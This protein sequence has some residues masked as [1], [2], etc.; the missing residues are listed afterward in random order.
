MDPFSTYMLP[1]QGLKMGIH[2]YHFALEGEFFR[3]FEGSLI[4][5]GSVQVRVAVDKRPSLLILD[6]YLSGYMETTC[7]R[8]TAPIRLPL[9]EESRQLIVKYGDAEE[10]EDNDEVVFISRET[11]QLSLAPYMYEFAMLALPLTNTY[12]CQSEIPAPCNQEALRI[13]KDISAEE[14]PSPNLIWEALKA[15]K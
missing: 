7:D 1:I 9:N 6:F 15:L 8:C 11:P 12:D 3:H 5:E 2:E 13:L 4:Q 10:D 14:Q